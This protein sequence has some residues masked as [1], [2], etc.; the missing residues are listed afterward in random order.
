MDKVLEEKLNLVKETLKKSYVYRNACAVLQFDM[1]TI[2]PPKAMEAQGETSAFLANEGFKLIKSDE[3]IEAAEYC[4]DHR[5]EEGVSYLD[6]VLTE[7][8]HR[9]Y[10]KIKNVT[11][12][13]NLEWQKISNKAYVKW[14][15]AKGAADFGIFAPVF[16]EVKKMNIEQ[17]ELRDEK[18]AT[19]YDTLLD[20]Y[21]R[22]ITTED[23]DL[24]FGKCRDRLVS[25]LAKVQA[26]D[27]KIRTDFLFRPLEDHVQEKIARYM[28]ETIGF[29]FS[30]GAF[31]TT[32]HPFTSGLAKNDIRV[33]T[34]YREDFSSNIFSIVHEGGHA[35]FSQLIPEEN[36][37][38]FLEDEMTMGMHESVSRFFENR[39]GRSRAFISLVYPKL[40]ELAPEAMNDVSEEE[41][42]E[43]VNVAQPSYIRTEADELTY[44]LHIIIRYELE[45]ELMNGNLAVADLPKAWNDKY[46]EYL[47]I[48]PRN[49]AEGVLQDVHWTWGYG[50]FP[51]YALGNMYNAMYF[52]RMK[53]ELDVDALIRSGNFA[54]INGW[55]KENVF[56]KACYL[57]PKEWIKEITG[58]DMT[59]DDY[60]DYLEEKYGSIYGF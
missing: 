34:H 51:T 17:V 35:L 13:K 23:L 49:D 8:L 11:P 2:C 6:R 24:W 60:L 26:S 18:K 7:M 20:D 54:A 3:F 28:L 42:Y 10:V 30:R 41:L 45:K 27:K 37:D 15:E 52:N 57:E 46:E 40:R 44:S 29:D 55:M 14:L 5:N 59:P 21:E 9:E 53:K 48:R 58:R 25:L 38:Y 31:T 16:E 22:G 12:E 4:Y 36:Y 50:Y 56:A 1:E 19:P 33:T 39:I 32:E 43:A 47:G